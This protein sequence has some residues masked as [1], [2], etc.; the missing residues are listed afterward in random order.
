M[1]ILAKIVQIRNEK[2]FFLLKYFFIYSF[3]F[4]LANEETYGV[5]TTFKS[6]LEGYTTQI[7]TEKNTEEYR[8]LE[9]Q[10]AK[11]AQEIEGSGTT[12]LAI[13]LENGDEEEAF[14]AVVRGKGGMYF[15]GIFSD[16][17]GIPEIA[18]VLVS[19]HFTRFSVKLIF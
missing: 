15:H 10:A 7:S 2:Y 16:V 8:K 17:S 3:F 4:S 12:K 5:Q 18:R 11:A 1:L 19:C 9:A 6:N 14:S 13:E